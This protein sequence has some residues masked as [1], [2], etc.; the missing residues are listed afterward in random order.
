MKP[1]PFLFL[2]SEMSSATVPN[3][4]IKRCRAELI[5]IMFKLESK[6][7]ASHPL[8]NAIL[9]ERL[10]ELWNLKDI[11]IEAG[12]LHDSKLENQLVPFVWTR[13]LDEEN[14][15]VLT[16]I[17][18]YAQHPKPIRI[19]GSEMD[20]NFA[21]SKEDLLRTS[22]DTAADKEEHRFRYLTMIPEGFNVIPQAKASL[23]DLKEQIKNSKKFLRNCPKSYQDMFKEIV[24]TH[25]TP[26]DVE[27]EIKIDV[28]RENLNGFIR[29]DS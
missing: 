15:T 20:F 25:A 26:G 22:K 2:F 19:I 10:F 28:N 27:D 23:D 18:F 24:D 11:R 13:C 17:T 12:Y 3:N 16:D 6:K 9:V 21:K 1:F 14:D 5:R 4:H 29:S 8:F 7:M